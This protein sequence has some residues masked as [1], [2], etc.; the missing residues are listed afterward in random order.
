MPVSGDSKSGVDKVPEGVSCPL[1]ADGG[2][3]AVHLRAA[4]DSVTVYGDEDG[5]SSV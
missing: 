4:L 3:S 5:L 2:E 1:G